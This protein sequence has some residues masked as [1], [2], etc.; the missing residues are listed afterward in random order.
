MDRYE[1]TEVSATR[2]NVQQ[3]ILWLGLANNPKAAEGYIHEPKT[4]QGGGRAFYRDREHRRKHINHNIVSHL[5]QKE[6]FEWLVG[7]IIIL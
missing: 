6:P 1:D 5:K 4:S 7:G 3:G 2:Q